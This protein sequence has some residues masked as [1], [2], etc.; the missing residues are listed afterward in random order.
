M[1]GRILSLRLWETIG[2][3]PKNHLINYAAHET[4][5]YIITDIFIQN[6]NEQRKEKVVELEK[7][8]KAQRK[9]F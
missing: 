4:K 2:S 9:R 6:K 1:S 7:E 3:S 8:M 5:N